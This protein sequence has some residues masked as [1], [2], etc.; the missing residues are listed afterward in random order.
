MYGLKRKTLDRFFQTMEGD[1]KPVIA[2]GAAKFNPNGKNELSAPTTFLSKRCSKHFST[3]L[4]D[5]YNTTKVCSCCDEKLLPV[6]KEGLEIRGLR[7]CGSTKCRTFLNRDLNAALNILRCFE[8]QTCRPLHL[9]RN[10]GKVKGGTTLKGKFSLYLS[11]KA[12]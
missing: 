12:R 3:I 1:I 9:S 5:E 6:V 2:Y 4:I 7:W 8:S 11:D 10:S